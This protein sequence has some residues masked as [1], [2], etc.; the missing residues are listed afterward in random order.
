M[1][2]AR[3]ATPSSTTTGARWWRCASRSPSSRSCPSWRRTCARSTRLGSTP[4]VASMDLPTPFWRLM[5]NRPESDRGTLVGDEAPTEQPAPVAAPKRPDLE[6][7]SLYFNRELSWLEFNDRVL[8]LAEDPGVPLLERAKFAAIW[9]S[10]L[11]EFFMV[12]V[13]NLHDQVEA[14]TQA[15]GADGMAPMEQILEIRERVRAQRD[16]LA[17]C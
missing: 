2:A 5:A 8:Q 4:S 10:N 12:R 3:S 14:G 15:R 11:D 13:A 7:A 17:R 16:R 1:A 6:D 9:E